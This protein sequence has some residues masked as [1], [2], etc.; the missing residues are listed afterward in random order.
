MS[1]QDFKARHVTV[2]DDNDS[3]SDDELGTLSMNIPQ[4]TRSGPIEDPATTYPASN[5]PSTD[6]NGH[7]NGSVVDEDDAEALL[8]EDPN[9]KG[10]RPQ[11]PRANTF[12]RF[13]FEFSRSV[14]PISVSVETGK[15]EH[16]KN[17][18]LFNGESNYRSFAQ[19]LYLLH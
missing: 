11:R 1:T 12:S 17:L 6:S 5:R 7:I 9:W 14:L 15:I 3:I 2:H 16:E 10:S 8:S 18:N 19:V 4:A 13:S